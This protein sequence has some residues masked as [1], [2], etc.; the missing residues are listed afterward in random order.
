MVKNREKIF[1]LLDPSEQ[2]EELF[3]KVMCRINIERKILIVRRKVAIFSAIFV[4]ITAVLALVFRI[5]QAE[6]ADSGFF[7]F[8]SLLFSDAGTVMAYWQNFSLSLLETIPVTSLIIFL[9]A[10]IIFLESLK[11]LA[12]NIKIFFVSKQLIKNKIYGYK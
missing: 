11:L 10:V 9:A 7:V 3:N 1:E 2:S 12:K 8:L 6:F 4:V 5:T